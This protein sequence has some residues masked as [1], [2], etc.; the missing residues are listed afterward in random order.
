MNIITGLQNFLEFI[1]D[2]WT[3]IIVCIGLI[4]AIA[5]KIKNFVGKS[6]EE[7][8]EIA[9]SQIKETILKLVAE[10]EVDYEEWNK[11]GSIKRSQVIN[12]I[13]TKFPILSKVI[14]QTALTEWIDTLIDESLGTIKDTVETTITTTTESDAETTTTEE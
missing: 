7:K 9:K 6:T 14:D 11:A 13:Y 10:A 12:Q 2:N 5:T 1:N 8:V 3:A 4:I